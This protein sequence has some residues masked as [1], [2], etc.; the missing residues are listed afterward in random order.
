[1]I[2]DQISLSN[3][4]VLD[5]VPAALSSLVSNGVDLDE[6]PAELSSSVSNGIISV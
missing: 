4:A 1:M 3:H 5:E 6:V 2:T